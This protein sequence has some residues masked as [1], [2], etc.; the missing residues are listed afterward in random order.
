MLAGAKLRLVV[1]GPVDSTDWNRDFP[2]LLEQAGDMQAPQVRPYLMPDVHALT[3]RS[4]PESG[5][6]TSLAR[7]TCCHTQP[8]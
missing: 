1:S 4:L 2:F 7:I 3:A 6:L 5:G 8:F